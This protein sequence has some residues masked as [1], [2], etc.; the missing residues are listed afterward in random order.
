MWLNLLRSKSLKRFKKICIFYR[1]NIY[2]KIT[3]I[4]LFYIY[5]KSV[6]IVRRVK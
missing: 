1:R 6:G 3:R 2:T 5:D 4:Y